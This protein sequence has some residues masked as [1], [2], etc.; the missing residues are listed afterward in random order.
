MNNKESGGQTHFE[1]VPLKTIETLV[2]KEAAV[3][4]R[5]APTAK[6]EPY[7]VSP[8]WLKKHER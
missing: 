6:T 3:I 2:R 5:E 7:S 4:V 8:A 1:Q